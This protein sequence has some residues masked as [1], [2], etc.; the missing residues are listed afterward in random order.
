M[1]RQRNQSSSS[2]A[3]AGAANQ[4][5][6]AVDPI[7]EA[8]QERTVQE[9]REELAKQHKQ[10]CASFRYF[11]YV[12]MFTCVV[13]TI[14]MD[15]FNGGEDTDEAFKSYNNFLNFVAILHGC[16]CSPALHF[17]AMTMNAGDRSKTSGINW[18]LF[19]F[20][21]MVNIICVLTLVYSKRQSTFED[22]LYQVAEGGLSVHHSAIIFSNFCTLGFARVLR[23]DQQALEKTLRQ[24]KAS[25]YAHK[26]L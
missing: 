23:S 21:G 18:P 24:L 9:F 5:D 15:I 10:I 17:Y 7:D 8:D 12:M 13:A 3:G 25:K 2:N 26:T 14:Y 11:V 20:L 22:E 1:K 19:L 4:A 16:V 6:Q